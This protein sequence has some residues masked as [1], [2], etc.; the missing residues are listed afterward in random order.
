MLMPD[1][2][3][4]IQANA[5]GIVTRLMADLQ[6]SPRTSYL[7]RL[8]EVE[9]RGRAADLYGNLTRWVVD[10]RVAEVERVYG[11]LGRDRCREG[12]R[13]S[14]LVWALVLA[15]SHL[16]DFIRRNAASDTAVEVHQEEELFDMIGRF[17]DQA[18][19]H[20]LRGYEAEAAERRAPAAAAAR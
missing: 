6:S 9:F 12:V 1:L 17:F 14:E 11:D 13:A 15:K 7:H 4:S 20:A 16:L 5:D 3:R 8:S 10:R 19:Y 2:I 18:I